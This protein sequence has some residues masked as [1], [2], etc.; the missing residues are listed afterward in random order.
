MWLTPCHKLSLNFCPTLPAGFLP[1]SLDQKHGALKKTVLGLNSTIATYQLRL[2][3]EFFCETIDLLKSKWYTVT[4]TH[5][6]CVH[7]HVNISTIQFQIHS[8]PHSGISPRFY[9]Q[10]QATA[11]LLSVSIVLP[12]SGNSH[13]NAIK[14]YVIL[15][16]WLLSCRMFLGFTLC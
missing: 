7:R 5:A 1:C 3:V 11:N 8:I 2:P 10:L 13:I 12:F 15:C 9:L 6:A 4:F 14:C 16:V